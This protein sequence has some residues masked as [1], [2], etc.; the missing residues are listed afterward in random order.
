MKWATLCA[1][2]FER[3][4]GGIKTRVRKKKPA[5]TS[6]AEQA[7][8]DARARSTHGATVIEFLIKTEVVKEV[9]RTFVP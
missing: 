2:L 3:R 7:A 9:L 8:E 5:A 6:E 4:L 1:K